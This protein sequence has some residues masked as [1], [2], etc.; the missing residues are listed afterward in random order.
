[1]EHNVGHPGPA[2]TAIGEV[3]GTFVV[4]NMFAEAARGQKTPQQAVTDAE[5]Q[6]KPIFEKWKRR[7]LIGGGAA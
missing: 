6:M 1:L 3:F 7:G 2:R 4:P 5:A